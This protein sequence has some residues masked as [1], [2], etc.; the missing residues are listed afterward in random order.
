MFV[1]VDA[2]TSYKSVDLG[3]KSTS[4]GTIPSLLLV[5]SGEFVS[6]KKERGIGLITV[7]NG[8]VAPKP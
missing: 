4:I 2:W 3:L 5:V 8:V 1:T 7:C 6:E